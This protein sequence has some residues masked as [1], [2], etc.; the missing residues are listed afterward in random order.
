MCYAIGITMLK[1]KLKVPAKFEKENYLCDLNALNQKYEYNNICVDE[2]YGCI[3]LSA[4]GN[5]RPARELAYVDE[6]SLARYIEEGNKYGINFDYTMNSVWSDGIEFTEEGQEKILVEVQKLINIG[7]KRV[8]ISSPG[9][10]K[11]VSNHFK[12][13]DITVSINNCV[14]SIH[15][16]KRWQNENVKKIV[17]NRHINRD[18]DLLKGMIKQSDVELEL[19]VNS[20]CNLYCSLHQ[21]HNTINSCNSNVN[22][23]TIASNYPQNQCA[24]NMLSNPI[25][26]MC[27]SWIRPEDLHIY[28]E[29]GFQSYKLD[30]RCLKPED[31]LFST[32][33]Y[34]ARHYDGNFFDLFDFYNTRQEH[35]FYMELD[36]RALDGF[37][38]HIKNNSVRC[39]LCGGNNINC[40]KIAEQI[41][42]HND[43]E[44]KVY[45]RLLKQNLKGG[46][47]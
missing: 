17:L 27:S 10:L 38:D 35:P 36:N 1:S 32:E 4:I 13:L 24:Y 33:A 39:S 2:T 30:G 40:K 41:Q 43:R 23:K 3:P 19:L 26:I 22:S 44:V 16:I 46:V 6:E 9:I 20:M 34:M 21:Y 28:D 31:V 47:F 25:E 42:C 29:L 5:A 45:T 18:F 15:A 8:S 12:N 14:D 7:V 37:L 11:L